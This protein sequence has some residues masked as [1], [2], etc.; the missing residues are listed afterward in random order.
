MIKLLQ[1]G[2]YTLIETQG[3]T[4]ILILGRGM[5]AWVNAADI[6]EI[7]V[8]SHKTH[9]VDHILALGNYRVYEV[10]NEPH[11]TDLVH[12]ELFVGNGRWQG[13]VLP[14]GLPNDAKKRNRIIP[15]HEIITKATF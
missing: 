4:K 15:T 13:Y 6:G 8:T 3:H 5:F 12:L 7:L 11:L 10:K 9:K 14:T 2:Q 1:E